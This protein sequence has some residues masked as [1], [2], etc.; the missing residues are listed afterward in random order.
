[1]GHSRALALSIFCLFAANHALK[2]TPMEKV[3][4]LL[5]DL[6]TKVEAEGKKEAAEYDK[7][8]CFCKEQASDKLYAI[9]KSDAKIAK[10]KAQITEL[11]TSIAGLN[12]DIATLSKEITGLEA[13][14]KKK[15]ETR[16]AEHEV[17]LGK[18]KD[19]NE[20]ISACEAAIAALKDSKKAMKGA[21]LD[22]AQI[23]K[24]TS[25][26]AAALVGQPSLS[27][28]SGASA[29]LEKIGD[30]AAPKFEYQS[31]DIIAVLEDLLA[32][33]KKM[34]KDLDVEEFDINA[35]FESDKLGLANEKTFKEKDKAQK[36]AIVAT[37]TETMETA[38]TDRDEETADR[39]AD[40]NFMDVL[41]KDCEEKAG[42]FDQRSSTRADELKALTDAIEELEKGAVPNYSA[43]K[44]LV[45]LQRK[46]VVEKAKVLPGA[47]SFVQ[48]EKVQ[49]EQSKR[50]VAI[51][52]VL[53][54]LKD[55]IAHTSST[56]LATLSLR[57][58]TSEDHFVKVR[59]LIK[60]LIA[61]LKEDALA[62]AD[63][64][65]VCD[66]GMAKA[67]TDRDDANAA[68]EDAEGKITTDT[69]NKT[70]KEEEIKETEGQVADLKKALL[71]AAELRAQDKANNAKSIEMT[72]EGVAAVKSALSIL[73]D[74]YGKA[75][76]QTGKYV[77]PDSDREGNTV[78]DL[79][80]EV[81]GS[82]YHG[83]QSESKG[84]IGI[85]E[86]IL[87]DFER[88][89]AKTKEDEELSKMA[90]E[91]FE[92]DTNDEI[93]KK[94]K[95][96]KTLEGEVADLESKIVD[97]EQAKKDAEDLLESAKESLANLEAMC[98]KGEETWEERKKKR[99]EEI[100]AL[101]EALAILEDWQK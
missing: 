73:S 1:M 67:T 85:L 61:R 26:L 42:L 35:A 18:A 16:E 60:D 46:S 74:F 47:V 71:E 40:Q 69:A 7:Y 2:V 59:G 19:M 23:K 13:E 9:E 15:T 99:M 83:A 3:I 76:V 95:K 91:M 64:K 88:T 12:A 4:E 93:A 77:P 50:Q 57:I 75:L 6:S 81:F 79:A 98:V 49:N 10:L 28:T 24:A 37:K 97:Q 21:K 101:K 62:E 70:D 86:V 39:A 82:K 51:Q 78:G 30:K 43:N 25:G 14:I 32:T 53:A 72:S 20:A 94:D 84:I 63:Q 58:S 56:S 38:K 5:K 27:A 8:A 17:Y 96:I 68:I 90:Y 55:K 89:E 48:V 54:L 33:F 66:K 11:E 45:G 29:L 92:T 100:A 36:E 44:K 34:K 22:F 65:S 87:S 52:K 80:P 41:T 31:N